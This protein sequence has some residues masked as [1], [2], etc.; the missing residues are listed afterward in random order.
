LGSSN[1][2]ENAGP[3]PWPSRTPSVASNSTTRRPR[4]FQPAEVGKSK[5]NADAAVASA[6]PPKVEA[7]THS[8]GFAIPQRSKSYMDTEV[9][10]PALPK[11]EAVTQS[12][13]SATT[14]I[15]PKIQSS[16]KT[17][18]ATAPANSDVL[19]VALLAQ[20]PEKQNEMI[21][22][23]LAK[24]TPKTQSPRQRKA[25]P[26]QETIISSPVVQ[27]VTM[28]AS[29]PE[30]EPIPVETNGASSPSET[31]SIQIITND[32]PRQSCWS[33]AVTTETAPPPK[34]EWDNSTNPIDDPTWMRTATLPPLGYRGP[35]AAN[36]RNLPA[37][38]LIGSK[39]TGVPSIP[40]KTEVTPSSS[41]SRQMAIM[42]QATL[43]PQPPRIAQ[44]R[45][46]VAVE[47]VDTEAPITP[48]SK[49]LRVSLN[50]PK[51]TAKVP[52]HLRAQS[53]TPIAGESKGDHSYDSRAPHL[54]QSAGHSE[55]NNDHDDIK[56]GEEI[57]A[58]TANPTSPTHL[59]GRPTKKLPPVCESPLTAGPSDHQVVAT[60][61]PIINIDEELAAAEQ[62]METEDDAQIAAAVAAGEPRDDQLY[63]AGLQAGFDDEHIMAK[64]FQLGM[65]S[66]KGED[67]ADTVPPHLR[68]S[69]QKQKA[70]AFDTKPQHQSS[71]MVQSASIAQ[72]N[73]T[74][75]NTAHTG[76][77]KDVTNLRQNGKVS[78]PSRDGILLNGTESVIKKGKKVANTIDSG[79]GVSDLVGWDGKMAPA[80]IGE[81]WAVR[82]QH[83]CQREEKLAVIKTWT[84][85]HAVNPETD[86]VRVEDKLL[87]PI[88][89]KHPVTKPN[90]DEFNQA[91]RHLNADDHIQAYKAKHSSSVGNT[92]PESGGRMSKEEKRDA[93]KRHAEEERNRVYPPNE[94][95]PAANIYLRP[96]EFKD[97]RQVC[98]LHNH[99]V[100]KTA[101]A[102]DLEETNEL[103]WRQR[104]QE[105][106]D[107]GDPFLVAVHMG[108]KPINNIR[109]I[110]R[111][112]SETIVGFAFAAD[113]GLQTHAYRFTV[114]LEMWVHGDHLH[115]G[116][117]RSM[118]DRMLAALDPGYNLLEC[119]P[120][121][122]GEGLSRWFSGSHCIVKT[123][124]VSLLHN[125]DNEKDIEWKKDWLSN[126]NDF[127]CCGTLP[128]MGHK[129]GKE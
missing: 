75:A 15:P 36:F 113:Y 5:P 128:G 12:Q 101:C 106:I 8:Q 93:R 62:I 21:A 114:E 125:E 86:V 82:A 122:G 104:L 39:N 72:D 117:G 46:P 124:L 88:S 18:Q 42:E 47:I 74:T 81:D 112:K 37:Y 41:F 91:K 78:S 73:Y 2:D 58:A 54:R 30:L 105:T 127:K 13:T 89:I 107:E 116:I 29:R 4:G 14:Q 111:K 26:L 56:A 50:T 71:A 94:H 25:Q 60:P 27:A 123:I 7:V 84:E 108:S 109:D 24:A 79:N 118:L 52:P 34:S 69:K 68:A 33:R 49:K 110:H 48:E 59:Q 87:S 9:T 43:P 67:R 40:K 83:G 119:A 99:Y 96:A 85:D 22:E 19:T 57:I 17:M 10:S 53:T 23:L 11:A 70:P 35:V 98:F 1:Q 28:D 103:Y 121:L 95:A 20:T 31:S 45:T 6:A 32:E 55:A 51:G 115:Q 64:H 61:A 100:L 38:K 80:L 90:P 120:F 16:T 66:I 126:K 92:T 3:G 102:H 77:L 65:G 63:A 97:M 129:F 44:S 76:A